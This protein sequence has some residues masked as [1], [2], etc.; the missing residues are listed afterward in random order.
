MEKFEIK[1][2]MQESCHNLSYGVSYLNQYIY[3]KI[4]HS[5]A[6]ECYL[7]L[8]HKTDASKNLRIR[9]EQVPFEKQVFTIILH[10]FP[11]FDYEYCFEAM[12]EEFLEPSVKVVHGRERFGLR[13]E[14]KHLRG[15]FIAP[16]IL[17]E[18]DKRL[19]IPYHDLILY[20][21][22]VR[23]FTQHKSSGVQHPGTYLGLVEKIPYLKELG[24]NA[25]LL[26]PI[27]EFDETYQPKNYRNVPDLIN[28]WGFGCESFYYAP[29]AS[30]AAN[31]RYPDIE[32]KRMVLELHKNGIEVLMEM[33][34]TGQTNPLMI[35]DC[36]RYWH[37]EY[38]ID[39]F[40]TNLM[41]Q[42]RSMIAADPL[43]S[44]VKLLD[45]WWNL[46]EIM[47]FTDGRIP[48]WL[49]E[50][51]D[52]FKIDARRFL[53]GDEEQ[54]NSFI[55]RTQYNPNQTAVINYITNH[56]GFTL[57]DV[58]MYD[59]KHNEAN[60]ENNSDGSEYNYSWNCGAEGETK[61]RKVITLRKKMVK[62]AFLALFLSQ[63]TPMLLAGD[64]FGNT[65]EGNNNGYCQDNSISWL[66]WDLRNKNKELT[67]FV[68]QIIELRKGHPIL[69]Q[70][71]GLRGMD[72]IYCGIPDIS[73]HGTKA[74]QPN[75]GYYSRE[76]G[77]LLC[78]KYAAVNRRE[79]DTTF[80]IL[81]NMHWEA[82]DF[83]LPNLVDQ[84]KWA[85]LMTTDAAIETS[86][87]TVELLPKELPFSIGSKTVVKVRMLENQ[88]TLLV[89]PRTVCVLVGVKEE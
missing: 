36:L 84:L 58:F 39:G 74:W 57:H 45:S 47:N 31:P 62:N 55:N 5:A 10:N 13:E 38:H 67:T 72:Y 78:G 49:A 1:S 30:Y 17:L 26:M 33:N 32:V 61:R 48:K 12:G 41:E 80:Y 53:K 79:F 11:Y 82:H 46:G 65:Q 56:D 42:Y 22:H 81:Y 23:G 14:G 85:M 63:G 40:K 75:L 44:E 86:D 15:G 16:V 54:V 35:I 4:I 68:K 52:G 8:Y 51:N 6:E 73:F 27:T 25:V 87:K 88:R 83:G 19:A 43:L 60:G 29:K 66:D 9:M 59:L 21:L 18:E 69:H 3:F 50:Y 37:S 71:K 28:Y 24:V 89:P 7:K 70:E 20:K 34:F 64:E 76:L 77:V 2:S